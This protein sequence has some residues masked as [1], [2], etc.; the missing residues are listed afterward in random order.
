MKPSLRKSAFASLLLIVTLSWSQPAINFDDGSYQSVLQRSK[1]EHK[2]IFYM[3]YAN[4]CSHCNKMKQD[5]FKEEKV[6]QYLN[7]NFV[8]AWQ[9]V[10]KGQGCDETTIQGQRLPYFSGTRCQRPTPLRF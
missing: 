2:N 8:C 7:A 4:W 6:S 10:E 3:L 5:V 1:D 9:D